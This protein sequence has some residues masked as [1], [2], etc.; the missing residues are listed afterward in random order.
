MLNTLKRTFASSLKSGGELLKTMTT[1]GITETF[2]DYIYG[3][4]KRIYIACPRIEVCDEFRKYVTN[5][6]GVAAL[7][8]LS[9]SGEIREL[10]SPSSDFGNFP[11]I[12]QL[13]VLIYKGICI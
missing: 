9:P 1:F 5:I 8:R 6:E 7:G 4:N 12:S 10:A 2:R 11:I 3:Q 13:L